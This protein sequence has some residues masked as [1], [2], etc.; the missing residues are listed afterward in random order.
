MF[1]MTPV[2][3]IE[4]YYL[5]PHLE[6]PIGED[7]D[8]TACH[9]I[10][11]GDISCFVTRSSLAIYFKIQI[12][13]DDF[14]LLKLPCVYVGWELRCINHILG[15]RHGALGHW[16]VVTLL[17]FHILFIANHVYDLIFCWGLLRES[18]GWYRFNESKISPI[19]VCSKKSEKMQQISWI[20]CRWA[21]THP[22]SDRPEGRNTGRES[23]KSDSQ[24]SAAAR[25]CASTL[26]LAW[27]GSTY[28]NQLSTAWQ[29]TFQLE[30]YILQ[31]Y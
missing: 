13:G 1:S 23:E 31:K 3:I 9:L 24:G 26:H 25:T 6:W 10:D 14:L 16:S 18:N 20:A 22:W 15:L 12:Q 5:A 19:S 21:G 29:P 27:P 4:N 28:K 7:G 2:L 11:Q 17:T 8:R 30:W